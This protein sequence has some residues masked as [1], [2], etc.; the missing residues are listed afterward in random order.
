M[1]P[2]IPPDIEARYEGRWIA[3][4]T[5]AEAVVG[6]GETLE[7]ALAAAAAAR[8]AGALIWYH[9]VLPRDTVLVGGL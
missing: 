5:A 4:D 9:H 7:E 1:E 3:W 8:E 2:R 6:E